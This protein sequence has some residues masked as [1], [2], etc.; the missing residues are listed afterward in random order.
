MQFLMRLQVIPKVLERQDQSVCSCCVLKTCLCMRLKDDY[1]ERHP[2]ISLNSLVIMSSYSYWK[3]KV[4]PVS[5]LLSY[6]LC[7]IRTRGQTVTK[8]NKSDPQTPE[9]D[10]NRQRTAKCAPTVCLNTL[11]P[12]ST[13]LQP[14]PPSATRIRPKNQASRCPLY[15]SF[16]W[17]ARGWEPKSTHS[18]EEYFGEGIPR[19]ININLI[20][21]SSIIQ[22]IF[23]CLKNRIVILISLKMFSLP[24]YLL[25]FLACTAL[26]LSHAHTADLSALAGSS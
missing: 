13:Y 11:T 22:W 23:L 8:G 9:S 1:E 4:R 3:N 14:T 19:Y 17:R 26:F 2:S 12:P 5:I 16:D 25:S 15:S 6:I 18:G 10:Y 7:H 24:F 21:S 20:K